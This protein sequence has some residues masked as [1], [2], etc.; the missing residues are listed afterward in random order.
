MAQP[1]PVSA[2]STS[3]SAALPR[4]RCRSAACWA[5]PSTSCSR[6]SWRPC[7]TA[8]GSTTS[9]APSGLNFGT[10]LEQNSFSK[11]VMLNTDVTHLPDRI[12]S[13]P[14]FT[15]EVD[16]T[17]QFTGLALDG[18]ADPTG[19]TDHHQRRR[20]HAAGDPRQPRHRRSG[21][22]LS[23]VH[24]RR[25]RRARR[26]G[27]QRHHHLRRRRRHD[28]WRR[29]ATTGSTAATATTSSWAVP[30]T[31]SSPTLGGDD[32]LQGGDGNDVINAGNMDRAELLGNLILGGDGKDFIITHRGHLDHV[33]RTGRRLHLQ[34]QGQPAAD[35]QRGRRLDREGHAGRRARRQLQPAPARRRARQR[36]LHRR[37]RLRRDDR[38]RRRR[39][40]RRQR[41]PGQDGRHVRLRLGDLQ[42]RQVRRH[43]RPDASPSSA[44]SARSAPAS[45]WQSRLQPP[46]LDPRSLRRGRGPVRHGLHRHPARR[47][48]RCRSRSSTTAAP[49][50][51]RSPT[52]T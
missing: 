17:K 23:A 22:Q 18:R 30:A 45:R 11:L 3:G 35:R 34:R 1:P 46:Q 5:R 19:G 12:F 9:R 29:A 33:R 21:Q 37:R 32:N 38:R 6:P 49:P 15:L 16:P 10:E 43:R 40:L 4:S 13:M 2:P 48:C 52:S 27:R 24:R 26:H 51:A 25:S 20:V 50:A 31:T 14:T 7:R 36:H 42:E 44:A 28:L 8:T 47:Q 39:H 41:C